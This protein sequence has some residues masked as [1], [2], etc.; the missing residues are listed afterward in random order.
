VLSSDA[1]SES[2]ASALQ[3]D[4]LRLLDSMSEISDS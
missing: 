1:F 2:L 4:S 3:I